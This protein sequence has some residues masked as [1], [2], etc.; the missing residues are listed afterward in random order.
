MFGATNTGALVQRAEREGATLN[1]AD[2][3]YL[4]RSIGN[5]AV[6]SLLAQRQP[7]RAQPSASNLQVGLANDRFEQEAERVAQ[8]V[9]ADQ[10]RGQH[11]API[12]P[13]ATK[14]INRNVIQR[15]DVDD[16]FDNMQQQLSGASENLWD[17]EFNMNLREN[18]EKR[19]QAKSEDFDEMELSLLE[20][21]DQL[22]REER[23]GG[24]H[25]PRK[26]EGGPRMRLVRRPWQTGKQQGGE[27]QKMIGNN[28]RSLTSA[29]KHSMLY[30]W[31]HYLEAPALTTTTETIDDQ[32]TGLSMSPKMGVN[33]FDGPSHVAPSEKMPKPLS[34]PYVHE[35][36][37]PAPPTKSSKTQKA[38]RII[39]GNFD[40]VT[41]AKRAHKGVNA[42]VKQGNSLAEWEEA[43]NSGNLAKAKGYYKR[44]YAL[45]HQ[46]LGLGRAIG[47]SVAA[48][49][50]GTG[51]VIMA[52]KFSN[53]AKR[54][55][56]KWPNTAREIAEE[57]S[58][59]KARD[60]SYRTTNQMPRWRQ[61]NT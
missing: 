5:R 42:F 38:K 50:Q 47:L 26:R 58:R 6:S 23:W 56:A 18:Q 4:Q 13:T 51:A 28:E 32:E 29:P 44:F 30:G 49:V 16:E 60:T 25:Q 8:Q 21:S 17:T 31:G 22:E 10:H 34:A 40:P 27:Q 48:P 33:N 57:Q 41:M 53:M 36:Y 52:T 11:P 61:N 24:N 19:A 3:L 37:T 20:L 1:T 14:T 55:E 43:F 59:P 54:F 15:D 2:I 46:E 45:S 39:K 12:T 9:T 7:Q 35:R